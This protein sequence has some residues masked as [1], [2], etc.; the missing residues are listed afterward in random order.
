MP[1]RRWSEAEERVL[2]EGMKRYQM[3]SASQAARQIVADPEIDMRRS[4][5]AIQ[6]KISL[7][8]KLETVDLTDPLHVLAEAAAIAVQTDLPNPVID[9][10]FED[11]FQQVG[12]L[13]RLALAEDERICALENDRGVPRCY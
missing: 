5:R 13:I 4:E 12:A 6:S 9:T 2:R 10:R 8:R 3:L 11:L 7:E 1:K